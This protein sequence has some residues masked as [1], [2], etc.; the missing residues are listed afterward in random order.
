MPNEVIIFP[1]IEDLLSSYLE[2]QLALHGNPV[3]V[4]IQIPITR[5]ESF[6]TMPRVGGPRRGLVVDSATISVDSWAKRPAAAFQL[7]TV[8]RGIIG[9]LPGVTLGDN[10]PIYRV[11]EF[12]GPGN[13]P[14]PL[15]MHSRYT[16]AFSV[17]V[18]GRPFA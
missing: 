9:A 2:N 16:Q 10:Y 8:V 1:D 14:D 3:S 6:V 12:T 18:R 17:W 11:D 13:M 15:S 4:H 7:A 5:P